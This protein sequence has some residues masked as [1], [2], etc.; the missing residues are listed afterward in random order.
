MMSFF[1]P[2]GS[3]WGILVNSMVGA[4]LPR[5]RQAARIAPVTAPRATRRLAWRIWLHVNG[6]PPLEPT[7]TMIAAARRARGPRK[8]ALFTRA[9]GSRPGGNSKVV[10]E[11]KPN[12]AV[13]TALLTVDSSIYGCV[14]VSS[15]AVFSFGF[16]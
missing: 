2:P 8:T 14:A 15:V 5:E 4:V 3:V 12:D 10:S 1:S 9:F 7:P 13:D 16:R 11:N 6:T